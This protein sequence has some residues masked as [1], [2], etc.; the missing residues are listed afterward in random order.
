MASP[1]T[2]SLTSPQPRSAI[3]TTRFWFSCLLCLC[4]WRGPMPILHNHSFQSQELAANARLAAH[5]ARHHAHDIDHGRGGWHVHF[6][7][8]PNGSDDVPPDDDTAAPS[9]AWPTALLE[10]PSR[11]S[12]S[13]FAPAAAPP[14]DDC[15]ARAHERLASVSEPIVQPPPDIIPKRISP[16]AWLCVARC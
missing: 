12:N 16:Q 13:D 1:H 8:P 6:I 4:A 7:M 14:L 15:D 3:G 2:N 10:Q 5:L 9:L 11:S